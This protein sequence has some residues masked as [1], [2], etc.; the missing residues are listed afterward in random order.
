MNPLET[1]IADFFEK[2][3]KSIEAIKN[4]RR[5]IPEEKITELLTVLRK[6]TAT[7]YVTV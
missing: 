6:N 1:Q 7:A 4:S 5:D 3:G 2:L